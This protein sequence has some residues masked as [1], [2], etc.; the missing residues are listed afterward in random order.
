MKVSV[1]KSGA[2]RENLVFWQRWVRN[3]FRLGAVLPSSQALVKAVAHQVDLSANEYVVEL[4]AGTGR[5]TRA[6][7]NRGIGKSQLF[8]LE[9]DPVLCSYLREAFPGVNVIQGDAADLP[10]LLPEKALGSVAVIV[11]G[12]PMVSLPARKCEA[13]IEACFAVMR[14]SGR[15]LQFTYGPASPLPAQKLGL[16]KQRLGRVYRNF[17]PAT[18]WSYQKHKA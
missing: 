16:S 6:L 14:R 10:R 8:V 15:F 12:I 5:V 1:S 17:P 18:I 3:P 2:V 9:I 11:S 4:G 7:L 13:I